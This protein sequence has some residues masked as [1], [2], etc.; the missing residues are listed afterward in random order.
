MQC[1]AAKCVSYE[2][3]RPARSSVPGC[4]SSNIMSTFYTHRRPFSGLVILR[5]FAFC[6]DF[7]AIMPQEVPAIVAKI[8]RANG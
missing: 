1:T 3:P 4:Y 8:L 5:P 7:G 6:V 2:G